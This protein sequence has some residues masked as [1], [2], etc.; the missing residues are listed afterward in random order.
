M[1]LPVPPAEQP[2]PQYN[3]FNN[4]LLKCTFMDV[5]NIGGHYWQF[6]LPLD[7]VR[8]W[9]LLCDKLS[10]CLSLIRDLEGVPYPGDT[11]F[12]A[13]DMVSNGFICKEDWEQL[14]YGGG[15]YEL[16]FRANARIKQP[17]GKV[18]MLMGGTRRQG[19]LWG[20]RRELIYCTKW[21]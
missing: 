20:I 10:T 6:I 1:S 4:I 21:G 15:K 8:T 17:L 12:W 9:R 7:C 3:S 5:E 2:P 16:I 14:V 19:W 13:R 11:T 18:G